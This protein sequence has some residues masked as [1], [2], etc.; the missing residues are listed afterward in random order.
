MKQEKS[1]KS[2]PL[3]AEEAVEMDS[4]PF[5]INRERFDFFESNDQLVIAFWGEK[6]IHMHKEGVWRKIQTDFLNQ[7]N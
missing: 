5:T 6:H 3:N 1:F 7:T 2:I 4:S